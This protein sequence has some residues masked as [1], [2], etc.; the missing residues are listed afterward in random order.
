MQLKHRLFNVAAL[1]SLLLCIGTVAM[2]VRS[3]HT[4][5]RADVVHNNEVWEFASYSGKFYLQRF[6][7]VEAMDWPLPADYTFLGIGYTRIGK[8]DL[9]SGVIAVPYWFPTAL[10]G[11]LPL[12]WVIRRARRQPPAGFCSCGYDLRATP[13]RCPEC[14]NVTAEKIKNST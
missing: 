10:A 1:I 14:G 12:I 6:Y 9:F 7:Y 13:S 11:V 5:Y 4:I 8:D 2:W 3:H